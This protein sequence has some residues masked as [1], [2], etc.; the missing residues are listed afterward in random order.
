M[1]Y[2]SPNLSFLKYFIFGIPGK[3][4]DGFILH[5]SKDIKIY[6]SEKPKRGDIIVFEFPKDPSKEFIKRVIALE[7]GKVEIINNKIYIND[8]LLDDP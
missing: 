6:K 2:F 7:D 4:D 1:I 8:K 5:L 3:N